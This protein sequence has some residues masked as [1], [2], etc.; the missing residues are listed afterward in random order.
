MDDS[1]ARDAKRLL[2]RYGAPIA[3]VDKLSDDE[4]IGYARVIIRTAVPKRPGHLRELLSDDGSA[5]AGTVMMIQMPDR[6]AFDAVWHDDP[7]VKAGAY[8][9]VEVH[10]WMF[11]GRR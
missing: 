7:L 11:G 1:V 5:W 6:A 9:S 3:V 8:R 4:R 2:L 10:R